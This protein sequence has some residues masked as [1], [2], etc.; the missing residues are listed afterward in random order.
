MKKLAIFCGSSSGQ[1]ENYLTVAAKL[2]ELLAKNKI[3]L[4]YGGASIGI[5]GKI[6]D[7]VLANNGSVW[8]IMPRLFVEGSYRGEIAH[9]NV[10]NFEVTDCMHTRKKRMYDL[11]DGFIALPGGFGTLDELCEIITWKQIGLHSKPCYLLNTDGFYDSF[12][13]HIKRASADG[14]MPDDHLTSFNIP[15]EIIENFLEVNNG[16]S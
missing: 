9:E 10:T 14:L 1:N 2:G 7:S 16:N 6:A 13:D 3:G 15:E 4:V 8:G 5:M 11:A 12:L